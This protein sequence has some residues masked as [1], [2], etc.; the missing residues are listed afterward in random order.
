MSPVR[1]G[2]LFFACLALFGCQD[3]ND[4]KGQWTFSFP[5]T[6]MDLTLTADGHYSGIVSGPMGGGAAS[7]TYRV[8]DG[9]LFM[10]LP[11]VVGAVGLPA[12]FGGQMQLKMMPL[13]STMIRL[14][15]GLHEYTMA[16]TGV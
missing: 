14:S 12:T 5:P 1:A 2:I 4:V 10:D 3:R 8:Q 16:R 11:S 13:S 6:S 9:T 15:D 7:G